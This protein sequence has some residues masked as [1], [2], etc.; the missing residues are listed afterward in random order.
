MIGKKN[1]S[2]NNYKFWEA[3]LHLDSNMLQLRV[4]LK[5]VANA[6]G[7]ILLPCALK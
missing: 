7:S 3:F 2:G 4:Q 6:M 1:F 5:V